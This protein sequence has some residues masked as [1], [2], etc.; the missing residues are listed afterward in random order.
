M[1]KTVA[2]LLFLSMAICTQAVLAETPVTHVYVQTSKGVN[3]YNA[4]SNGRLTLVEG[5][6]FKISGQMIGTSGNH[7]VSLG[8]NTVLVYALA[9]DGAIKGQVAKVSTEDYNGK[10]CGTAQFGVLD[11]TGQDLYVEL[12]GTNNK[13]QAT[14]CAAFQSF[15][16]A[17]S[18]AI[19][20]LGSI[21][22]YDEPSGTMN[23]YYYPPVFSGSNTYAY[24]T[25][26]GLSGV[27]D[28][29]EIVSFKRESSGALELAGTQSVT[30]PQPEPGGW[31]YFPYYISADSS[32][33]LAV[34]V[35]PEKNAPCG[36]RGS[37]QLASFTIN[38]NGSI[39]SA[40]KYENM[41]TAVPSS[42][43]GTV[44]GP[45][46]PSGTDLPVSL[47]NDLQLFHLK[48][49]SPITRITGQIAAK[50][51]MTTLQWDKSG[52]L[53]GLDTYTGMLRIYTVG[54][55]SLTEDPGSPVSISGASSLFVVS[56]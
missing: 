32:D 43:A 53:Y 40:N 39:V 13:D 50:G 24:G 2:S 49:A 6:P 26:A 10:Q 29:P 42:G 25:V 38:S 11:R 48:G 54:S 7:F 20:Y 34:A 31:K 35:Q 16:I 8:E 12:S 23:V 46:S 44:L 17:S 9:S 21:I 47:G 36:T 1:L 56:K 18:G 4:A 33:H 55:S 28:E 14:L 41:P 37:L 3:L 27:C 22:P 15:K 51:L 45:V 30:L 19:S 52:H 5:S